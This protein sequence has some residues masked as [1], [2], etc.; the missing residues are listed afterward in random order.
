MNDAE[1]RSL[2]ETTFNKPYDETRFRRLIVNLLEVEPRHEKQSGSY[3]YESFR[4]YVTSYQRTGKFTDADGNE[5]DTLAVKLKSARML[6]RNRT[7]QRNFVA[8][9][10]KRRG[11]DAALVAFYADDTEDWRFSLIKLEYTLTETKT[12]RLT[13]QTDLTPARRYS[14]LVGQHEPNHTAQKQLVSLLTH[15]NPTLRE[16][17][18][19][20]SIE[21]VTKAFFEEYKARYLE[22]QET[23]DALLAENAAVRG[24]FAAKNIDTTTFAKRLLGQVVFLYF[25]QKKGWLG[26]GRGEAWGS[27]PKDFLQRLFGGDIIPYT[28]FYDDVLEPLFYDALAREHTDNYSPHLKRRVPFLNGGLFEP[29]NGYDWVNVDVPLPNTLFESIFKTFSTYNFTVREDEPLE[30]E[31]AVDPEMLGK[32]F[33]NL[34]EVTDRKSKGAFYTPRE[35]V[36]YMCQESLINYLDTSLNTVKK[37]LAPSLPTQ[38]DLFGTPQPRQESLYQEVYEEK[39]PRADLE[40]FI[41]L[42]DASSEHDATTAQKSKETTAYRFKASESVRDYAPKIDAALAAIKIC[43]PAIGSGAFPV[44]MMNE[45]VRSRAALTPFL[46]GE[47]RTP[48]DF[49]RHAIQES[50]YGVDIDES[51]VDIAKLRLWLSL[52]VDE[53]DFGTIKPLPNLEYKIVTGNSLLGVEETI[54][55]NEAFEKLERLQHDYLNETRS[56]Q[57]RSLKSQIEALIK[58]LTNDSERFDFKIYFSEVF[59]QKG[60]FDVVIGNPP[61]IRIQ[62]LKKSAPGQVK[63]FKDNYASASKGNYDIYVVF[64]EKGINLLESRGSLSYILPHKFFNAKYGESIRGVIAKGKHLSKIVHFGDEQIFEGASTYVCLLFLGKKPQDTFE[65]HLAND[66]PAWLNS[67]A[68]MKG[69]ISIRQVTK[70]DWNFLVGEGAAVFSKL[71]NGFIKLGDIAGQISQG[72]R[73]SGNN[74]YV[75]DIQESSDSSVVG[76]SKYLER[77]VELEKD[78]LIPFLSGREI[79]RYDALN[80]NKVVILP[81]VVNGRNV[82]LLSLPRIESSYPKTHSYLLKC[83]PFL[84]NRENGKMRGAGWHGYVYPKNV[85]LMK[86][87]KILIPDIANVASFALDDEGNYAFTSGYGITL[88]KSLKEHE[89]YVLGLLNSS[90]S[91]FFTQ[92]VSTSIRGGYLRYFTQYIEQ[93]PIRTID[94]SNP[95]DKAAHDRM[96][97]MVEAMLEL[98]GQKAA[99][100]ATASGDALT[101]L[102]AR[103]RARRC[104]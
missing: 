104:N 71:S 8:E 47:A 73:T 89:F 96:T 59:R 30:R 3:I 77:S 44:G 35:I 102:E 29:I 63:F 4:D 13:T 79:K 41:R 7:T 39:V 28:N 66:L 40:S 75:L 11:K 31:V 20:F 12:G 10:L 101:A 50:L 65:F 67:N 83:K 49:K 42:G 54:F 53:D 23:L 70:S 19:Q 45:I 22:L 76:Y 15:P 27:G 56:S 93:L 46:T 58:E 94:F 87:R 103:H 85:E 91:T 60:G 17:E 43:D 78:L 92:I 100:E 26:V 2:I 95:A 38:E 34:L 25:L 84:E 32:V 57:K 36:H 61:Y 74:V 97:G 68:S 99:Q 14:F 21:N 6:E 1:A 18:A 81:Y 98:Q 62:E 80:P 5:L 88:K 86:S 33:E 48:Y 72:I 9:Y 64:V 82:N 90:I 52:V 69:E 24:E 55:N 16:L 51:A 37:P